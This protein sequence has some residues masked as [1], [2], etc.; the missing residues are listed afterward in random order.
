MCLYEF[1]RDIILAHEPDSDGEFAVLNQ[2][3]GEM[4]RPW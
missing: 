2:I 1:I 4:H 3:H